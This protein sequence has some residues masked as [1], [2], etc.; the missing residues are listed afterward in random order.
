MLSNVDHPADGLASRQKTLLEETDPKRESGLLDFYVRIIPRVLNAERCSLFFHEP[1]SRK[2]WLKT[3][4]GVA[5]P[6]IEVPANDSIVGEVIGSGKPVIA[7][8]LQ[9]RS[10]THQR[11]HTQT[12]FVT[13]EIIRVPIRS[14]DRGEVIGA[15]EV[16]NK[17]SGGGFN[18]EDQAFLE[19]VGEH[20]Q[21][22]VDSLFMTQ[23]AASMTK[24]LV[25]VANPA[26]IASVLAGG[27]FLFVLSLVYA[28][29]LSRLE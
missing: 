7:G 1:E 12:G 10:G 15:I 17:T 20:L 13:R 26:I 2:V 19:E 22:V 14:K 16:L 11:I 27:A 23:E 18:D 29:L 24:K 3:G 8:E 5:K 6:G 28:A 4:P 25:T 9:S 21:S